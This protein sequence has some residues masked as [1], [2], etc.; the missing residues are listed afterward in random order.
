MND[1]PN[2]TDDVEGH[3]RY[4]PF[5]DDSD[6]SDPDLKGYRGPYTEESDDTEGHAPRIRTGADSESAEGD[7]DTEAHGRGTP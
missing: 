4:S 5:A 1:Q 7:T 6:P 2:T 3:G